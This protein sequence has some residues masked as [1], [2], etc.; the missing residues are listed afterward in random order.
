MIYCVGH[1]NLRLVYQLSVLHAI[2]IMCLWCVSFSKVLLF[3]NFG[4]N[5]LTLQKMHHVR[6]FGRPG[7]RKLRITYLMNRKD[8]FKVKEYNLNEF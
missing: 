5:V 7:A 2:G 8:G 1:I 3:I 4:T 6:R